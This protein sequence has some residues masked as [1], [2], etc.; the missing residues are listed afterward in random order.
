ME[1][2]VPVKPDPLY[3]IYKMA[4]KDSSQVLNFYKALL[5]SE[6][7]VL[8]D[9]VSEEEE[10][11][12]KEG[13]SLNIVKFEN[14]QIP[15]FSN[16]DRVRDNNKMKKAIPCFKIDAKSLFELT[17]GDQLILNPFSE[18]S[19]ILMPEEINAI[20]DGSIFESIKSEKV[21]ENT[22]IKVTK[23]DKLSEA[24]IQDVKAFGK[25]HILV[26]SVYF[27]IMEKVGEQDEPTLLIG[28]KLT[29]KDQ[30]TISNFAETMQKHIKADEKVNLVLINQQN[31]YLFDS[32]EATFRS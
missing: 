15:I 30:I 25:A 1:I 2:A 26:E 31:S 3:E 28:L 17:K 20:L 19:K 21:K 32:I 10:K 18:P 6:L 7:V 4:I 16:E 27:A 9:K 12:F 23:A 22:Q 8:T 14:G 24:M 29:S 13:E 11:E 5:K